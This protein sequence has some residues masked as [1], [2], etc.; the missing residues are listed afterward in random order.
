MS[1]SVFVYALAAYAFS[2]TSFAYAV[3]FVADFPLLPRT[4]DAAGD[5]PLAEAVGV[6]LALLAL[7]ALQHSVMARRG[8]KRWWTR[9][10]PPAAERATYVLAASLALDLLMWQWRP[11]VQPVLWS[12]QSPG[13]RAVVQVVFWAGWVLLVVS[14][15]LIDHFALFGLAQ[16]WRAFRGKGVDAPDDFRT[17][18]FYRRVRHP[19][20][21]G[22]LLAFWATPHMTAGHALFAAGCTGYILLGIWFEERDLVAQFGARYLAYRQQAGM[23]WPKWRRGTRP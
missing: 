19:I 1:A 2:L 16:P 10:V 12:L 23:L 13:S 9:L 7:F 11:I 14:T 18:L 6:D 20:Y 22:F 5:V 3:G 8:F 4:I 17:P 21:L 15:F